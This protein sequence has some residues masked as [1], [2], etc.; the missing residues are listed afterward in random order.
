MKSGPAEGERGPDTLARVSSELRED[1]DARVV[2]G[3]V[4]V[5]VPDELEEFTRQTGSEL[6]G[7]DGLVANIGGKRGGGLAR[8]DPWRLACDLE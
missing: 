5:P 6:G 2:T 7:L 4:D 8:L 3:S 1:F